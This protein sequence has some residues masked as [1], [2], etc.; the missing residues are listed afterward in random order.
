MLRLFERRTPPGP[1][2]HIEVAHAG[3]VYRVAL[4]RVATSQRFT[5]RVRAASRDVLLTMPERSSLRAAREFAER[6]AA[7]IGA[8]LARLPRPVAFAAAAV[9]P[10]RGVD[11]T[12]VHRPGERGVVWTET[13]PAGPI[14]CVT[15]EKSFIA[16]RVADFL[17]VR[18]ARTSRRRWRAIPGGSASRRAA[19]PCATRRAAGAPARRPVGSI[20]PGDWSSRRRKSSTI[21]RRTKSRTSSI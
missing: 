18:R 19:S 17:S 10:L 16:R 3:E 7:W 14:I 13:G 21:S 2:A 9:T 20:S 6:H 4:K 11:H 5:L 1:I 15:G 8:R 12:I